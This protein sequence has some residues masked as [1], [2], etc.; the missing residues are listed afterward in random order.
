MSHVSCDQVY[1][2]RQM[3]GDPYN[4]SGHIQN[5]ICKYYAWVSYG[6]DSTKRLCCVL[7]KLHETFAKTY[8][9]LHMYRM[10]MYVEKP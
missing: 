4:V 3:W 7:N 1:H 5:I 2:A 10:Y 6:L 8:G 9:M